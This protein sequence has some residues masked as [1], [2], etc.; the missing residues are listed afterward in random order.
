M[1]SLIQ[2]DF[3]CWSTRV[4]L[5]S[6]VEEV[7]RQKVGT[8]AVNTSVVEVQPQLIRLADVKPLVELPNQQ[9][10]S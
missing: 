5:L 6:N 10:F 9:T 8:K 2:V 7:V 1:R 3:V 4:K